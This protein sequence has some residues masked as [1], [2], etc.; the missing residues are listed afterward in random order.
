MQASGA[1]S[2]AQPASFLQEAVKTHPSLASDLKGQEGGWRRFF[3]A[4][5]LASFSAWCS[6]ARSLA[7]PP[8][9]GRRARSWKARTRL[10]GAGE[11]GRFWPSF[12]ST[13]LQADLAGPV[14]NAS[15]RQGW[16]GREAGPEE[17]RGCKLKGKYACCGFLP[18]FSLAPL[19]FPY[20]KK[21]QDWLLGMR[22]PSGLPSSLTCSSAMSSS[23][24][25][26]CLSTTCSPPSCSIFLQHGSKLSLMSTF[27]RFAKA[28]AGDRAGKP[29]ALACREEAGWLTGLVSQSPAPPLH[30]PLAVSF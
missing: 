19:Q 1:P 30:L 8:S 18:L 10:G 7:G 28:M 15:T 25:R 2:P 21:A 6:E 16:H 5:D 17:T 24:L 29:S 22:W 12:P 20:L 4:P 27:R 11:R 3:A 14:A 13:L 23:L 26:F 9:K